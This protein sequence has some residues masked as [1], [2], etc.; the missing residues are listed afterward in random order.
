MAS[1]LITHEETK[2]NQTNKFFV[3]LLCGFDHYFEVVSVLIQP[4]KGREGY[5]LLRYTSDL[6]Y[7]GRQNELFLGFITRP[8]R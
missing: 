1:A 4:D 2:Q 5:E 7:L 6:I 8:H 3:K